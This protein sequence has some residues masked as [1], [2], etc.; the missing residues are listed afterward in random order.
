MD[1]LAT[2]DKKITHSLSFLNIEQK[3]TVLNVVETFA[4]N[5]KDWWD[6]I[7]IEQ[8]NAI[9]IALTEIKEGKTTPHE[10]VMKKYKKWMK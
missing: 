4:K 3:R 8:Q 1:A 7:S 6:E 10:E 9:D 2:L 5:Q